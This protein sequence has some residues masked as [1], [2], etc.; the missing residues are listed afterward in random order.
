MSQATQRWDVFEAEFYRDGSLRD[1]YVMDTQLQ[2]WNAAV[3]FVARRYRF[4]FTDGRQ[5]ASFPT[6]REVSNVWSFAKDGKTYVTSGR[7]PKT[8]RK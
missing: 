8:L 4:W 1:I 6:T 2:D 5:E 3:N 7:R